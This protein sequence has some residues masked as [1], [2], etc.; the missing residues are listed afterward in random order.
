MNNGTT[1]HVTNGRY[2]FRIAERKYFF[3]TAERIFGDEEDELRLQQQGEEH[4]RIDAAAE[5]YFG[6]ASLNQVCG[7]SLHLVHGCNMGCYYCS[8]NSG[9]NFK[10]TQKALT[11]ELAKDAIDFVYRRFPQATMYRLNLAVGGEPLLN[12]DVLKFVVEYLE[13]KGRDSGKPI[14]IS[15]AT[16]GLLLTADVLAYFSEKNIHACLSI[17]GPKHIHDALR[18]T[19]EGS[20]TYDQL[21]GKITVI[22]NHEVHTKPLFPITAIATLSPVHPHVLE[23]VDH[24]L[25]LG[26]KRV[27]VNPVRSMPGKPH[28]LNGDNIEPVKRAYTAFVVHVLQSALKDDWRYLDAIL[29]HSDFVGRH[30]IRLLMRNDA[31]Y[32]CTA[33]K[34]GFTIAADGGIYPCDEFVGLERYRIG[35]IVGGIDDDHLREF[36]DADSDHL[37]FCSACWAKR[38]CGGLC[39]KDSIELF[40]EIGKPNHFECSLIKHVV[41]LCIHLT[42]TIRRERPDL[43]DEFLVRK[44]N[45]ILRNKSALD[46]FHRVL[47]SLNA[48]RASSHSPIARMV[49][50]G[51]TRLLLTAYNNSTIRK[52]S[53]KIVALGYRS[54]FSR[55]GARARRNTNG[56]ARDTTH[57][58]FD[59]TES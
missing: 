28:A 12:F 31:S 8:V 51:S 14:T 32:R 55:Y 3:D 17:D 47:E 43:Y 54:G 49:Y 1:S 16:N 5:K 4:T 18:V 38:M 56:N 36:Y 34:W 52:F 35:D 46:S 48:R 40:G 30:L 45:E 10:G 11:K 2:R 50:R 6:R 59:R 7:F 44:M 23:V 39:P 24:L 58:V 19:R 53:K 22:R 20:P 21:I 9:L 41:K 33:G 29:N 27:A 25:A 42:T 37:R 26:F 57:Y 15:L 13:T